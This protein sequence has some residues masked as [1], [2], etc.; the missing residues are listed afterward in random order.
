MVKITIG[1]GGE[2]EGSEADIVEG[3]VINA[4]DLIGVLDQLMD[5]E[6]GVVGLNDGVGHLGGWHDG[7]SAHH[8]VG[9]LLTDLGDQEGSHT[10]AG[11]TTERVG[12]LE[13][14]EAVAALSLLA[15]NI[16]DGVNELST[17]SVVTLG[18]VVTSTSLTE[19]EVVGSEELTE[20]TSSNRVHCSGFEIHKDS[21]WN[22][23]TTSCFIIVDIDSFELKI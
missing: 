9:V 8:T 18:P 21:S 3:L 2:L 1:G 22:I 14:L 6:G 5:G 20:G 16:E 12:D 11:T 7:E 23:S 10:G 15:N 4:H 19:D 13:A 17:L